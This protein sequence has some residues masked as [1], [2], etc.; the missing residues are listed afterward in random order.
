M[1]KIKISDII[2]VIMVVVYF[3]FRPVSSEISLSDK[4]I[5]G[6]IAVMIISKVAGRRRS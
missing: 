4:I 2:F 1:P 6:S 3:V 5:L